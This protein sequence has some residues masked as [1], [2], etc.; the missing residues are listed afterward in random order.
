MIKKN[1]SKI[2][3]YPDADVLTVEM[4]HRGARISYASEVGDFIV[5]F[6]SVNQ[7][8][9]VEV[10]NASKFLKK[11][12]QAVFGSHGMVATTA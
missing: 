9:L 1:K 6:S 3:Y 12:N 5:H 11:G 2:K 7:P 8:I 10:L 4:P